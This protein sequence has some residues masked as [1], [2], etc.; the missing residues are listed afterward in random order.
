MAEG[1][2]LGGRR[3]GRVG[4]REE[5]RGR[6]ASLLTIFSSRVTSARSCSISDVGAAGV[7]AETAET[8]GTAT[9]I[10]LSAISASLSRLVESGVEARTILTFGGSRCRKSSLRNEPSVTPGRSP[11]SCCILQRS[12]VGLRSP[13]S[14]VVNNC[15]SLRCSEAAVLRMSCA[16]RLS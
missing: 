1:A 14:S 3:D 5:D 11:R 2:G 9:S 7:E 10:I 16:L 15:W 4:G 8:E 13:R 6:A 12:C